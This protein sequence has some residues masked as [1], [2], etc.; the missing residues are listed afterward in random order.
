[1]PPFIYTHIL[2]FFAKANT[3]F[4]LESSLYFPIFEGLIFHMGQ[5]VERKGSEATGAGLDT[6][7]RLNILCILC[8]KL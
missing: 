6:R 1:M 2:E 7:N 3:E 8:R 5:W 4:F